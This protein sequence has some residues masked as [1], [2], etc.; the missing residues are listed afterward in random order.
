MSWFWQ[1]DTIGIVSDEITFSSSETADLVT[2]G[3]SNINNNWI[4][5]AFLNQLVFK[6]VSEMGTIKV[7]KIKQVLSNF[8]ISNP[9][10]SNDIP[11]IT[12]WLD[13]LIQWLIEKE[14]FISLFGPLCKVFLERRNNEGREDIS[15]LDEW[16]ASLVEGNEAVVSW[17]VDYSI[18]YIPKSERIGGMKYIVY[19]SGQEKYIV[20]YEPKELNILGKRILACDMYY[21][22]N[23]PYNLIDLE[24]GRVIPESERDIH[25]HFLSNRSR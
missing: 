20:P 4:L 16:V 15:S 23:C 9:E 5:K 25:E 11:V 21:G 17:L 24:T 18:R 13:D 12:S 8:W 6:E 7:W 19:F 14:S 1:N 3:F 10:F 2:Y 22:K